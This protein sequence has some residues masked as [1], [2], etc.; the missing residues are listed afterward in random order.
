MATALIPI[1]VATAALTLTSD[2]KPVTLHVKKPR[3]TLYWGGAGLDG[4]YIQPQ[5]QAF[6]AAGIQNVSVGL[7]NTATKNM[8]A[9]ISIGG[10][11]ID[12]IRSGLVIRYE[13]NDEWTISSGMKNDSKQFNLVGY[14]YGSLLAAQTA[15]YYAKQGHIVDHLVLI[16]S[17]IDGG[18]LVKLRANKNIKKV[19]VIDLKKVGDQL[20][21]GMTQMELLEAVPSLGGDMLAGKGEGHFYYAH[22]VT[23][24]PRRWSE[25]AKQLYAEGLR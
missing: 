10:T 5:L 25:L 23:D 2:T 18:F 12:G 8:P 11:L 14:S 24:S 20:Y 1:A 16:G 19:T 22:V 17:P 6:L 4:P 21:A 9:F 7:N 13:D 3:G 15:H